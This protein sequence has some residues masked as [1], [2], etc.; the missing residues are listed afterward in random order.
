VPFSAGAGRRGAREIFQ[1][2]PEVIGRDGPEQREGMLWAEIEKGNHP[3]FTGKLVPVE[4]GDSKGRKARVYVSV[5]CFAVGTEDDWLRVKVSGYVAQRIADRLGCA[6]PTNKVVFEAYRQAQIKLVAHLFDC[7][8]VGGGRWQRSTFACRL[9]EEVLQGRLP[10]KRG[11]GVPEA[12]GRLDM[13]LGAH[14]G[15]C[16]LPPGPHPGVLV[17]GHLKEVTVNGEDLSRKLAF[18]GF[19]PANGRPL[20]KGYG[21]PHGPGF[22][23]YS[24][25]VRLVSRR[26]EL[27]GK[28]VDYEELVSDP[29]YGE[30]MFA[31]GGP[32]KRPP[33]YPAPPAKF[34]M[35]A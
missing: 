22:A 5:D 11:S 19:F 29:H 31:Q 30:L 16:A 1:S 17:A 2:L 15:P 26:A 20:Q 12:A 27:D 4:L 21:A 7:Q 10:C 3:T 8:T 24:H 13:K 6:L 25:G 18:A 28:G 35:G 9:H 34:F 23:D 33:R 14:E 32:C